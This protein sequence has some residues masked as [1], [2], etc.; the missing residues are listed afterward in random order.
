M[1]EPFLR[2]PNTYCRICKKSI[3]RRPGSLKKSG[4]RA[5]CSQVCYGISCRKESPCLICGRSIL[6]SFNKKTCSRSCANRHRAGIQYKI[7]RPRDK[8]VSERAIKTRLIKERGRACQR[9]GYSKF[10]ILQVHHKDRDRKNNSLDNLE[11]I[12][13]NCHCEEHFLEKSWLRNAIKFGG[14]G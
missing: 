10:E 5:F 1:F 2:K 14:V 12:C 9:C 4:G 8:V 7:N 6:A 3:Y 13:P 11:L